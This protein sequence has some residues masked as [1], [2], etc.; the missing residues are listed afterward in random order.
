MRA[1]KDVT[2]IILKLY[3]YIIFDR[4]QLSK[5]IYYKYVSDNENDIKI[6]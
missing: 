1:I 6:W 4:F 5:L 3:K 2:R